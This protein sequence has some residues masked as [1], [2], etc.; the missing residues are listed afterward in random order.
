MNLV[1]IVLGLIILGF[2]IFFVSKKKD[3]IK[4]EIQKRIEKNAVKISDVSWEDQSGKRHTEDIVIKRSRI[5]LV[6]DWSR[7]YPPLNEDGKLNWINTFLGGKKNFI[8]LLIIL[9]IVALILL[10]FAEIFSNYNALK[11]ICEPCLNLATGQ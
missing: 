3:K 6:G 9:G 10:G 4:S 5:P 8:K 1:E 7:I 2:V 11:E